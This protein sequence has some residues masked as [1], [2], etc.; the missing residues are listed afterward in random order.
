LY[1]LLVYLPF[2]V[3]GKRENDEKE[4]DKMKREIRTRKR[5]GRREYRKRGEEE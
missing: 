2:F 5:S 4:R 1:L 3:D